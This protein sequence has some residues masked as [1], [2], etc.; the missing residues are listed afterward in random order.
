MAYGFY[1][2]EFEKDRL[3]SPSENGDAEPPFVS[4][5]KSTDDEA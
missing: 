5:I 2:R 3:F 1:Q 4:A